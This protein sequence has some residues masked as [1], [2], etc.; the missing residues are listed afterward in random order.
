L[1]T[2]ICQNFSIVNL[3]FIFRCSSTTTNPVCERR[4]NLLVYSLSLHRHSYVSFILALASSIRNKQTC[5]CLN[6]WNVKEILDTARQEEVTCVKTGGKGGG[7]G[8]SIRYIAYMVRDK[9]Q[10]LFVVHKHF[11]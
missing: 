9:F 6:W 3:V 4:V 2:F 8:C 5:F 10:H 11:V 7:K 1:R